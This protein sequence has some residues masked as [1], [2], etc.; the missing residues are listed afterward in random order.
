V[1]QALLQPPEIISSNI[2][3]TQEIIHYFT[4]KSWNSH[5]FLL[6][7]DLAKAFDRIKWNFISVTLTRLGLNS[8]FINLVHAC[9]STSSLAILVNDEPTE[10]FHPQRGL[11][12]GCPLSPYLFVL[13]INELSIRLRE[14]LHNNNLS[15]ISL[16]P[17]APPIH[18]LLFAD[19]LILCGKANLQEAQ[20]IK[21][22][23]YNFCHHSGQTPNLQKSS[24]YFSRNV[25]N[26]IKSQIQGIFPVPT[27]Q[28][29]TMHLG[30]SFPTMIGIKPTIS[31]IKNF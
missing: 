26:H 13:A 29:N 27:L 18:S 17:G 31:F 15:G 22:I 19:D 10:Y 4:L 30:C 6:K 23:L 2:I 20:A 21:D 16:G 24:I 5:A 7:I 12:Q 3:T 9:I 8:T 14:A 25:P 1:L 11:R 28:P